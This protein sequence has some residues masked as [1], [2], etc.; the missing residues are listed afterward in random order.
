[1]NFHAFAKPTKKKKK[2]TEKR[3][4]KEKIKIKKILTI[5]HNFKVKSPLN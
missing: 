5:F 2:D 4:R 1:L 3:Y